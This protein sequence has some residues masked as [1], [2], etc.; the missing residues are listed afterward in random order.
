M[1]SSPGGFKPACCAHRQS[2]P[3][4]PSPFPAPVSFPNE[5]RQREYL[6]IVRNALQT[7]GDLLQIPQPHDEGQRIRTSRQAFPIDAA[8]GFR[9]IFVPGNH[10]EGRRHPAA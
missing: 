9:R 5:Q 4:S 2:S 1:T 8:V 10:G 6:R 7:F 3:G